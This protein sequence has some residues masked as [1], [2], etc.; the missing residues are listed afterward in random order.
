MSSTKHSGCRTA[1]R[2][3]IACGILSFAALAWAGGP[4]FVSGSSGYNKAGI[5]MGWYTPQP[6]YFTDPGDLSSYVPHAQADAMVA[7]AAA[8]WNVP[9]ANL[10]L[11]QGGNLAEH[12]DLTDTYFNGTDIVFPSD[13]QS[14]NYQNIQIAI[15]Y[16]TD[17]SVIDLLL[18]SGASDPSGCLQNGVL[19]SV[20]SFGASAVIQHA[21]ILLNGRCAGSD[22]N[23]LTQMQYQL[24]RT[25]GRVLGLAWSQLNDSIF[26][27]ASPATASEEA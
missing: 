12:V 1:L 23:E 13:V 20:D 6:L 2:F 10:T 19:E 25:F 9:T 27:G 4:R 11:T 15:V 24:T 26:T 22:P 16:D 21:I 14:T 17:G 8:T 18:G 7:A 3:T 5:P